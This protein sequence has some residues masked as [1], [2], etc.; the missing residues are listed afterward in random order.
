MPQSSFLDIAEGR[1]F[2]RFDAP[3]DDKVGSEKLARPTLLFIHACVADHTL[4]DDQVAY[5]TANG[6][7]CL[8]YDLFGYGQ[9]IPGE[10]YLRQSPKSPVKHHEHTA[11]VVKAF[12]K[13]RNTTGPQKGPK[14]VAVGLSCGGAIAIDFV[15][16]DPQLVSGLVICAGGLGGFSVANDPNEDAMF[17]QVE[18]SISRKD[19]ESAAKMNVRVWGDGPKAEEGRADANTREKLYNWCK[20]I[21]AREMSREGGDA[22]PSEDLSDPPAAER[23]SQITVPTVIAVGR[24]D[25]TCTTASMRQVAQEVPKAD[26]KEFEAAHMI[27]LECPKVFNDWL[28]VFLG[29]LLQ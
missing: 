16:S 22:I 15:L 13:S 1:I 26:I 21:A 8:R 19:I 2:W 3:V 10:H 20:D 14:I 6:W 18:E 28:G 27:N 17:K 23:L 9:S 11:R 12:C 7:G 4:W 29:R 25:E 5:C 24:Y